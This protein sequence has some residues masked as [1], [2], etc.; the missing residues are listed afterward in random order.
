[1]S[2][3]ILFITEAE[4]KRKNKT[5]YKKTKKEKNLQENNKLSDAQ[6]NKKKENQF[7]TREK[8][9]N[10][11]KELTEKMQ[12][13][14]NPLRIDPQASNENIEFDNHSVQPDE[15]SILESVDNEIRVMK[16]L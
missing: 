15:L 7:E 4:H 13:A 5:H 16:I 6:D 3:E 11:K 8:D 14:D 12:L 2:N 10:E 1:M 9:L